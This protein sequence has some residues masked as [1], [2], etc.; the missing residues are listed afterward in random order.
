MNKRFFIFF[1]QKKKNYTLQM[2]IDP[3]V[4]KLQMYIDNLETIHQLLEPEIVF[5]SVLKCFIADQE[6]YSGSKVVE[7]KIN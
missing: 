5:I 1:I 7:I 3:S 6:L 4:I 2:Y